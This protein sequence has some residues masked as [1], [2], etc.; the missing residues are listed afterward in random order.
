[1]EADYRFRIVKKD[2]SKVTIESIRKALKEMEHKS[3]TGSLDFCE[4]CVDPK[5]DKTRGWAESQMWCFEY[6]DLLGLSSDEKRQWL[7]DS[8]KK[9]REKRQ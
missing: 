6:L 7:L 5:N 4:F 9:E 2:M 1:M 8:M 3:N